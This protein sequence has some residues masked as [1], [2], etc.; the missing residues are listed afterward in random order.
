MAKM[1]ANLSHQKVYTKAST[2][3]LVK[4][5][6][7]GIRK[8]SFDML[9]E[10]LWEG[11]NTYVTGADRRVFANDMA[12][13]FIDRMLVDTLQKHKDW[14]EASEKLMYLKQGIGRIK[15]RP[16]DIS[17]I[18]YMLDSKGLRHMRARWGYK[19]VKQSDPNATPKV[20]YS[21]DTFVTD[22]SR[23]MPGMEHLADMHIAE[24]LVEVDKL[25][26]QLSEMVKDKYESA[27][28]DFSDE[29][30]AEIRSGIV[31]D[32][33][34]AYETY[35][36]Q[37]AL[38]KYLVERFKYYTDRIDY[39]KAEHAKVKTIS[40]W[41]GILS[42]K[43]MHIRELK[44]GAFYNATQYHPDIFKDSIEKL[45]Q[46]QWR[47]NIS[48]KKIREIFAEL[49]KWYTANNPMLFSKDAQDNLFSETIAAYID[50]IADYRYTLLD[51]K[52]YK[53]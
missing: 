37:S 48:P 31:T 52:N 35:G 9:T 34:K 8:R 28:E 29:W 50:N 46:I 19:S 21:V 23:E 7:P 24:A 1:K 20:A 43:A 14:D 42:T 49:K 18:E 38:S 4:E 40:R 2:R 27:Y 36:E 16:E 10:K 45:S 3:K 33:L 39:W 22:L 26:D 6:A 12:D 32:I 53:K 30:I 25:Y 13:M 11:F 44:K 5:L 41:N 47:G 51:S 15:F 17:E